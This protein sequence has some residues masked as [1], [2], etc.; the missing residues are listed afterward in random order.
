MFNMATELKDYV[1]RIMGIPGPTDSRRSF[2]SVFGLRVYASHP[3]FIIGFV[4]R[5]C[6]DY[7]LESWAS[8]TSLSQDQLQQYTGE[9]KRKSA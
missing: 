7:L 5:N 4:D 6:N 8:H 3:L 9:Y 2:Y 1:G